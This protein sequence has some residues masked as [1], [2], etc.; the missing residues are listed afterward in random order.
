[1]TAFNHTIFFLGMAMLQL[2]YVSY[3]YVLFRRKEFLY[4]ILYS[5]CVTVFI[6]FKA[7]PEQNPFE[8][9]VIEDEPFTPAR[10][11]LLIGFAMYYK[12]GRYF[13]ESPQLY[14]RVN[15]LIKAGEWVFISFGVIDISLLLSGLH[16]NVLEPISQTIYLVGMPF[17]LYIILFL[18]TRRRKLTSILVIG[19]GFLLLFAS[20]AFVDRIFISQRNQPESYYLLYIELGILFEFLFLNFGLIYK[21]K[22]L[23]NEKLQIEMEK[24]AELY[25]QRM[26][27]SSDL[28]DEV[29]ATLS[30]LALYSQLT[31]DQVKAR[32][33]SKVEQSLDIM[34][35][36][37]AD[38]VDKLNDIVWAVNPQQDTL[39]KLWQ[40]LEDYAQDMCAVKNIQV[41]THIIPSLNTARL[42]ME[43]RRNIYLVCKEAVNNAVKYSSCSE[44]VLCA[45]ESEEGISFMIQDN[46]KGFEFENIKMGN[47]LSNQLKRAESMG[48][49]LSLTSVPGKGTLVEL[50]CKIQ[51]QG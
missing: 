36:S 23:Q 43:D 5:I 48:A 8:Q 40:K 18:I 49:K 10:S 50:N 38:M 14:P 1:M 37:A 12:F 6:F 19:S 42:A 22:M 30:G 32:Q 47:G 29:G 51:L 4:Y 34:Q 35:K 3:Q 28:H 41:R 26:R 15:R 25:R 2:V 24:Q 7:F 46:G 45:R 13:T 31:R 16:F 27:I 9:L 17:S 39:E 20:A 33:T 21:T 44:L 11:V